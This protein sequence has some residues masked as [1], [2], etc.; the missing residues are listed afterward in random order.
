[1]LSALAVS[2][3]VLDFT[4][5]IRVSVFSVFS[6]F[7]VISLWR[8][9]R[10]SVY[11]IDALQMIYGAY[12]LVCCISTLWANTISEAIF[13]NIK[14]L[15]GYFV[16][17]FTGYILRHERGLFD[18]IMLWFSIGVVLIGAAVAF[19]QY[20]EIPLLTK[21]SLY[22]I[23]GL[24]G[25][26]NLYSSFLFL[27]A[28]F[29]M[30]GLFSGLRVWRWIGGAALM[31]TVLILIFLRT[32]AVLAGTGMLIFVLV[33]F[34]SAKAPQRINTKKTV[35]I[36]MIVL[37]FFFLVLLPLL[38][39]L[40]L[41]T[42]AASPSGMNKN[43]AITADDERL[44]LWEKTYHMIWNHPFGVGMGNWQIFFPEATLSG[45]WRAEDLNF[46]FQRPHN[47]FLWILSETGIIGFNLFLLFIV[48]LLV[49]LI[50]NR[51]LFTKESGS[52]YEAAL[53][54]A[55]LISFLFISFFDFPK[56]RMEH[57]LWFNMIL[58]MTCSLLRSHDLLQIRDF[59]VPK[60]FY[61]FPVLLFF[62]AAWAG[63]LRYNGEFYTRKMYNNIAAKDNPEA[64]Y[65]GYKARSPVYTIDPTSVPLTWYTA[66][67]F[68]VDSNYTN[69][70]RDFITALEEAP[71]N[72]NVLND[73]GS[74]YAMSGAMEKA[75]QLYS[76]AA[77]ISPRFDEPK[78]NLAALYM[79]ERRYRQ[80]DSCLRLLYHDSE[81]RSTYK[82]MVEAFK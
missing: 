29:L 67:A 20:R 22:R 16:F 36:T 68:V 51:T 77:R 60:L 5:T 49:Q 1:M 65:Y 82:R 53:C 52:F 18:R 40:L 42:E 34:V 73:L 41:H 70:E 56:E 44:W 61:L 47:D 48:I 28:F 4:L 45:I 26:K 21:E 19:Y 43:P 64:I 27:N 7:T 9:D 80:A 76:E 63:I 38:L 39:A 30:R 8:S 15:L 62:G 14:V 17:L 25:H 37:N 31:L 81:R 74:C 59:Q 69:A 79:G 10:S 24:N 11:K 13:E 71:Y 72:R 2:T 3:V 12:V 57:I 35:I 32:K 55:F 50:K 54:T 33:R 78:L 75:K 58:G 23:T 6:F 66:N 46:T